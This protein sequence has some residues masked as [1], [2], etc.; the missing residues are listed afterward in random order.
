MA[1]YELTIKDVRQSGTL[2]NKDLTKNIGELFKAV[3]TMEKGT[4]D[5]AE[6]LHTIYVNKYYEDDYAGSV[7]KFF[8]A[9]GLADSTGYRM[10]Q[11]VDCYKNSLE[12]YGYTKK[13][14]PITK[15]FVMAVLGDS[16]D[17]FIDSSKAKGQCIE[18]MTKDQ[19]Q[20]LVKAYLKSLNGAVDNEGEGEGEGEG[21]GEAK[22][23][24][25]KAETD[26]KVITIYYEEKTYN[27]PVKD[28]KKYEVKEAKGE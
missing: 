6:A 22:P 3:Y 19:L 23:K 14:F 7:K 5:F 25:V 28:L 17:A 10:I 4:W 24:K 2:T 8:K 1:N 16:I 27:I 20:A 18:D 21:K 26:G 12:K 9:I 13:Q 11:S 15:C